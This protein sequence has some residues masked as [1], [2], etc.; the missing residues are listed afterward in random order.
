[1][2]DQ[3]AKKAAAWKAAQKAEAGETKHQND[4]IS[5][6]SVLDYDQD[7]TSA[8]LPPAIYRKGKA[9]IKRSVDI[10]LDF[11]GLRTRAKATGMTATHL[12]LAA[13]A[14]HGDQLRQEART[15]PFLHKRRPS[16]GWTLIL[17]TEELNALDALVQDLAPA[18]GKKSRTAVV[19][20]LLTRCQ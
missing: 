14:A 3:L 2:S 20:E 19:S 7:P 8:T 6:K 9:N 11:E 12:I 16:R 17:S 5:L 15:R 1:M 10:P 13:A 4:R 18:F